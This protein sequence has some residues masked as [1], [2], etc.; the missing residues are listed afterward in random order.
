VLVWWVV[1]PRAIGRPLPGWLRAR[2]LN[3]C[4]LNVCWLR[5][6]WL[7]VCWLRVRWLRVRWL[8]DR[9]LSDRRLGLAGMILPIQARGGRVVAGA[10]SG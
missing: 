1:R 9:W 10:G 8:S 3:V 4:W 6:R 5:V 7:N 2:W